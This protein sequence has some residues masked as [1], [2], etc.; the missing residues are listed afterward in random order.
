M[1]VSDAHCR[2]VETI[3]REP[4]AVALDRARRA[5]DG[6]RDGSATL[7][8]WTETGD[9]CRLR[10]LSLGDVLDALATLDDTP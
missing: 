6:H 4:L 9:R 8:V 3:T 1:T 7:Y 5:L 2:T 10:V